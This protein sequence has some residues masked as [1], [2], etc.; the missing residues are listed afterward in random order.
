[1]SEGTHHDFRRR[2]QLWAPR[3][4]RRRRHI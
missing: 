3:T 1:M 4:R 2:G